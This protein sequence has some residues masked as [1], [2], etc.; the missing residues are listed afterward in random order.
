[1]NTVTILREQGEKQSLG[2]CFV[3]DEFGIEL[4]YSQ[5]IEREWADN[6][7]NV[8]CIPQGSYHL[9]LEF[10]QR[11]KQNLWEVKGV[12]NRSECKFHAANYARQLNGCIALGE[13]RGDIDKDGLIDITNSRNTM[14]KF[15][16]CF[17]D[18]IT[19]ILKIRNV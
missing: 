19:A 10:S 6:E 8:S 14:E 12:I 17:N 16:K 13:R 3:H 4:F 18:D 2:T 5:S 1:M 9:K 7:V 15:H 11:F